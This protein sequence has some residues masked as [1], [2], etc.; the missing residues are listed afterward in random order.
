MGH[1]Q[2]IIKGKG[3]LALNFVTRTAPLLLIQACDLKILQTIDRIWKD[4][5]T[6][7]KSCIRTFVQSV[8]DLVP[9]ITSR[10]SENVKQLNEAKVRPGGN[11]TVINLKVSESVVSC[12]GF[13]EIGVCGCC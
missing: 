6:Y 8:S 1:S 12:G 2:S 4:K 9:V 10:I 7:V 5:D 11:A 13:D 3:L